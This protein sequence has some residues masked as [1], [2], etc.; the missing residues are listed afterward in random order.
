MSRPYLIADQ[1]I[2][3]LTKHFQSPTINDLSKSVEERHRLI[4]QA[5]V[6]EWLINRKKK[7]EGDS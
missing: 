5:D 4:G 6:V 7:I 2:A 1:L 3:E